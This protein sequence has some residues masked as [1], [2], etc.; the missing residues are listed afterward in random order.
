MKVVL[1]DSG[2]A[3]IGSVRFA[4]QRLGVESCL[5]GD[6]E[7]VR[8]ADRVILPGVGAAGSA[9]RKLKR[10]GLDEVIRQLKQP[11]LGI[12]LGMQLMFESSQEG[13]EDCL[14]IF[15]GVACK[16]DGGPGLRI[17][18]MGWNQVS[19]V[20]ESPLLAGIGVREY[21]YFVHSYALP[22]SDSTVAVTDHGS[23]FAAVSQSGNFYATQFHPEKSAGLGRRLLANFMSLK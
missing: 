11:V 20:V 14:G 8:T 22:V 18:H 2:G 5:S 16:L 7:T 19:P 1:V 9:M 15:P 21:A 10:S 3:N 13:G 4:L 12:C 6:A 23:S 17:P